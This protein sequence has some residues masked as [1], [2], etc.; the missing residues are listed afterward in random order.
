MSEK[1]MATLVKKNLFKGVKGVH[2]KKCSDCP[3]RKQH[4]V[5]LK[6]QPPLKKHEALDFVHSN[7]CKMSARKWVE[8]SILSHFLMT[9]P[10][11]TLGLCF[12][13]QRSSTVFKKFQVSVERKLRIRSMPSH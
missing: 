4:R 13:D 5:E 9:S 8:Q 6:S 12:E 3:A 1:R 2:N 10:K 7:L 11:K